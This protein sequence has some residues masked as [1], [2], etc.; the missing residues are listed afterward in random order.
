MAPP[1][2]LQSLPQCTKQFITQDTSEI[3]VWVN[4]DLGLFGREGYCFV[5]LRF[6]RLSHKFQ[7][8]FQVDMELRLCL[9]T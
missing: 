5:L 4:Q 1:A 9:N 2:L 3:K 6:L 8:A 7:A